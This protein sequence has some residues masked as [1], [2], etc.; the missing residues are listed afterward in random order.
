MRDIE[1]S[2]GRT[3][4]RPLALRI[5]IIYM[6]AGGLWIL[7]SDH[8][9]G[10][11]IADPVQL[12]R[13]QT[14]KGWF[15]V[16][17]TG[18]LL[19]AL[20]RGQTRTLRQNEEAL[21]LQAFRDPLT[22]LPNE[23][24]FRQSLTKSLAD[25]ARQRRELEVMYL[26][27]DRFRSLVRALGHAAGHELMRAVGHRLASS[28]G[29]GETLSHLGGDEFVCLALSL[30]RPEQSVGTA[31]RL[32]TALR[33]PFTCYSQPVHLS[34]SIG[35]AIFPYDGDEADVLLRHAYVA[36][37][38]AKELGGGH[39]EFYFPRGESSMDLLVLEDHL[40]QALAGEEFVL[41]YQ[42]QIDGASGRIVGMEAL[43]SW[44]HPAH[45]GLT[46]TEFIPLAEQTGLIEPIGEWILRSACAQNRIWQNAGLPPVRVAVNVSARQFYRANLVDLVRNTLSESGL[47]ATWLELEIT[48]SVLLQDMDEAVEI[49][50]AI[51]EAGVRV[52]ID[53][54]GTGYS[55]LSY[56][57]HLPVDK[58]KLDRSFV[59]ELPQNR[60]DAAIVAAVIAMAHV[61]RV[62]VVAEGVER[63]E[64]LNY[65]VKSGCDRIQGFLFS[66]PLPAE[67]FGR[68]LEKQAA[69]A[70]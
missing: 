51:K 15:F 24:F 31:S 56:L 42:P 34:A 8:L 3:P 61:L 2:E 1:Q 60:E 63:E 32:L 11:F 29:P 4:E 45:P 21:R 22:G 57:K 55:S 35:I 9:L 69:A 47:D 58:L 50:R 16:A 39:Y 65:L 40:R 26:D 66:P 23:Q 67:E 49:L 13:V 46:P 59:I 17:L 25:A 70:D 52:A 38:R 68:L 44:K 37:C 6:V 19:Y 41:H 28:L 48:E 18:G 53:D 33:D 30:D 62:E 14:Y 27:F 20:I 64:Q 36:M 10:L 43:V 7:F 12:T 54:F 5:T